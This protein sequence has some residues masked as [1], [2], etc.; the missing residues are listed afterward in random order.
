MEN[1]NEIYGIR[2]VIEAINSGKQVEKVIVKQGLTGEMA[3]ELLGL[4]KK[5]SIPV[6]YVPY[7]RFA[8]FRN[9]NHQGVVAFVPPVELQS[10]EM[11]VPDLF[12]Q[13]KVPFLLI[14]DGI[15]DVRNF[16]A[17]VRTAECAGVD[18][19]IIPAKGSAQIGSDSVKTSAGALNYIPICK[20]G[21]L[22]VTINFLRQSGISVIIASEKESDLLFESDLKGPIAVVLGAEDTGINPEI[23]RVADQRLKIPVRG[24]IESLNVSVAAGIVLYEVVRQRGL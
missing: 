17:I 10:I 20:V 3:S 19:I 2:P 14:L 4:L 13:G 15:T 12:E 16:G 18:A 22:K 9:R 21:S 24:K 23:V 6:Q 8:R 11:I 7:E 1:A 5:K